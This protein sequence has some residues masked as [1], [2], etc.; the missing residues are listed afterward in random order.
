M[1]TWSLRLKLTAWSAL[2]TGSILLVAAVGTV[3]YVREE[4]IEALDDQLNSEAHTFYGLVR[5]QRDAINWSNER[6]V[7]RILPVTRTRRFVE[8]YHLSGQLLFHGGQFPV[9]SFDHQSAGART[10]EVAGESVRLNVSAHHNL[11]LR[12]GAA[13]NEINADTSTVRLILALGLPLSVAFTSFGGWWLAR[14]ALTPIREI[15]A[16]VE[17]ITAYRLRQRLPPL[18][19]DDEVARLNR[20]LNTT[21]DRLDAS[22]QQASRFTADASHEL[23][24]PLTILRI[25]AEH[26]LD[27]PSLPAS[28][29]E[30]VAALLEQIQRVT[31]ITESLLL[32][33]RADAGHLVLD[34]ADHD[35]VLIITDCSEDASI[36]AAQLEITIE[37]F[38]PDRI[39]A[40]VDPVRFSQLLLNLFINA[41]KYNRRGGSVWIKAEGRQGSAA[42]TIAN[43]GS[44]IP[45]AAQPMIFERFYRAGATAGVTGQGLGLSLAREL[46]RAQHGDVVLESSDEH[47]T[48][49]RVTIGP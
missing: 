36:F 23:K 49:F 13:L 43:T 40:C 24:T 44:G 10:I 37:C 11:I 21:F 31:G 32:L 2:L 38:L 33:S 20:V 29:R 22:F 4:Q 8:I 27:S 46:A 7:E 47:W 42:I 5:R 9:G 15:T 17:H 30:E 6:E 35:L 34:C 18:P 39:V 48:V 3:W 25:A 26:L 19:G 16:A 28:D 14:K 45:F 1:K 12:L 41:V